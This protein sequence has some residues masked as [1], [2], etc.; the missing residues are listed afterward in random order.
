MTYI[1]K[2]ELNPLPLGDWKFNDFVG[3]RIDIISESRLNI[4]KLYYH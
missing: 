4:E 2:D 3:E 1:L